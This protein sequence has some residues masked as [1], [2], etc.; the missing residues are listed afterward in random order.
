MKNHKNQWLKGV[1]LGCTL[2][3][4]LPLVRAQE[5]KQQDSSKLPPVH[6]DGTY[7]T[8]N[9][10]RFIP[11]G[12]HWVPAKAAM[13]WNV[14]WDPKDIEADFAKMH[15]LGY[16]VTRFDVMWPWFEPR[17][18]D[19]NPVAFQQL[20]YLISLAHKYKIYLHPSLFI[21]GEVGEAFWDVPWRMGRHPH[22]D[23]DMLRLETNLAAEFGRRYGNE[24]AIIG[25]DLT[26]EPPFWIV[27]F[28]QTTDSMAINWTRLIVDGIREHDKLHPVVVGTSGEEIGHGPFRADNIA[29]FVDF[30]SVHPFTLYAPELFP[31]ALLSVRGTYG[32]AFE[33][34]LSQGAGRP[35]MIHEMGASTAQFSPERVAAY[36]RAQIYSG[37]GAGSIGVDLWCYTDA[38]PQQFH[39]APYLRTPQETGWGMTTWDRQDKPLAR[40]FTKFSRVVSQ[41]DLTGISPA[42]AEAGIVIP[43]E[44]AKVHGDFSHMGLTGPAVTPYVSIADGD[45]VPGRPEPDSSAANQ[46]LMSSGLTS[47]I[48]ARQAGMKADFPRE[49]ND[50]ESRPILYMPSPVTSTSDPFLAHVHSD[51]YEKARKYVEKGGFLYASLAADGAVPEMDSLFGARIVDRAISTEVTIKMTEPFG[52]LK[53]GDTFHYTVPAQNMQSWGVLL[54]VSTGKVVAVDQDGR[55]A[56]V[57]NTTGTGKTLL[58][59]YPIEHYLAGVP[60]VFDQP[61]NT[62]KLYEA[63]RDWVGV[64][65]GFRSDCSEVEVSN[66]KGDRRGYIVVV[67][68]SNQPQDPTIIATVPVGSYSS[69]TPDGS[70]PLSLH[71]TNTQ[72]HLDPYEAAI[73]EWK[74]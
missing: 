42:P 37:F 61:E 23:P 3:V 18:G 55:P 21:G 39:K 11:V 27:P 46:W 33:I 57:I 29:K 59:A 35:V 17:P 5:A 2:L 70:K 45:A 16:T 12:A 62:K 38:S 30:F 73:I 19:Y 14:E 9:G 58:S 48:L 51:F 68:H 8:A 66:L 1:L 74:Q 34:T 6:L 52:N 67:N 4:C 54:Q 64:K 7:F 56:L 50:W 25:W 49:Y 13:Q 32:A 41:L 10:K 31:D 40:E 60:A 44:W 69:I 28:P 63:F 43:D 20:D 36:D 71:G 24:S 47:F 15:E 72:L 26:D 65:P 22:A 53:P